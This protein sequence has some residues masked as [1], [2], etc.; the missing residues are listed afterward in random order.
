MRVASDGLVLYV[1][2]R[3]GATTT[4]ATFSREGLARM[5]L[6]LSDEDGTFTQ[7]DDGTYEVW[8]FGPAQVEGARMVARYYFWEIVREVAWEQ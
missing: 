6:A 3:D 1:K 7:A 8:C 2:P 4:A 5:G